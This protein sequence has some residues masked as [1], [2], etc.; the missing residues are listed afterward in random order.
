[1]RVGQLKQ[2]VSLKKI[3]ENDRAAYLY[4]KQCGAQYSANR[5]D[6]WHL[7]DDFILRCCERP[8]VRCR[9]VVTRVAA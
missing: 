4:C 9:S 5:G 1:M 2:Q 6:Y 7:A 8:L 3:P